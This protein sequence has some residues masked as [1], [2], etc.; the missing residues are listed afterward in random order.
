MILRNRNGSI[1]I[2]APHR[3]NLFGAVFFV[4]QFWERTSE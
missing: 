4:Q 3:L 1:N 2:F